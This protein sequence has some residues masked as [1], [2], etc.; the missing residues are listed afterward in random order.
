MPLGSLIA[1]PDGNAQLSFDQPDRL[2]DGT[3]PGKFTLPVWVFYPDQSK[4][5]VL[6][7]VRVLDEVEPSTE[8]RTIGG[9]IYKPSGHIVTSEEIFAVV[10]TYAPEDT[11]EDMSI[12]SELPESGQNQVVEVKVSYFDGTVETVR[13]IV[14]YSF[15][16][17]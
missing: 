10:A 9:A 16:E 8:A 14:S 6:V 11:V 7:I 12:I 3:V 5:M 17:E 13:V 4:E 1:L 2:P 15:T